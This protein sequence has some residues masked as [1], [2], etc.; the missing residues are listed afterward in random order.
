MLQR[1]IKDNI[2]QV[3][4]Q[5]EWPKKT[6][7]TQLVGLILLGN[8]LECL[9]LTSPCSGNTLTGMSTLNWSLLIYKGL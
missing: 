5:Q 6:R 3:A 8:T 4:A 2:E 9:L 7:V 1:F